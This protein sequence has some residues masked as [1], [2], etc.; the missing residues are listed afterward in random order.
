[1]KPMRAFAHFE[2]PDGERVDVFCD[3]EQHF[4]VERR[5]GSQLE[6]LFTPK[7]QEFREYMHD[8]G[9]R[10]WRFS[11]AEEGGASCGSR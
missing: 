2:S 11:W 7:P 8:L 9:T 3:G 10:G 4:Y 5:D 1:M 6:R